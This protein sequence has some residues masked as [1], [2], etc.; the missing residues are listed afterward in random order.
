MPR[1][2][3]PHSMCSQPSVFWKRG[4]KASSPIRSARASP[5]R[6]GGEPGV[7]LA[8]V[9]QRRSLIP[10]AAQERDDQAM[11]AGEA[12]AL[13]GQLQAPPVVALP[14]RV[15]R[16]HV[17]RQG[18]PGRDRRPP[19]RWRATRSTS[20]FAA[21]RRPLTACT[22]PRTYRPPASGRWAPAVSAS[23][24]PSLRALQR[25]REVLGPLQ[26]RGALDQRV[27]LRGPI[28]HAPGEADDGLGRLARALE[29]ADA[30]EEVR[31]RGV[32]GHQR[33]GGQAIAEPVGRAQGLVVEIE[34]LAQAE[35]PG[36]PSRRPGPGR[37]ARAPQS[38]VREK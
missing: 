14:G 23:S 18:L 36:R 19:A 12:G 38:S 37:R 4:M 1:S 11:L 33:R 5:S 6:Q 13:A 30:E 15:H 28:L 9:V 3:S 17:Q 27:G 24:I 25:G 16:E 8:R 26:R 10:E 31:A 35:G 20:S 2:R 29:V 34:R 22:Y 32:D 7:V 21:S